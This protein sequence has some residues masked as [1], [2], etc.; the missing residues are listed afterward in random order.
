MLVSKRQTL[1]GSETDRSKLHWYF[2]GA[3]KVKKELNAIFDRPVNAFL[4]RLS[5]SAHKK[6]APGNSGA[7]FLC[8]QR[9]R[10]SLERWVE[11]FAAE[12]CGECVVDLSIN[13]GID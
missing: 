13:L 2:R 8:L 7:F 12:A 4:V 10:G 1:E 9:P 5:F 3:S 11:C 6:K